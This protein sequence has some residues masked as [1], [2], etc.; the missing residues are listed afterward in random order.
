[1]Q[2]CSDQLESLAA[3]SPVLMIFEDVHWIDPTSL[4]L[5]ERTVDSVERWPVLLVI[6]F[7][8]EFQPPWVGLAHVTMHRLNKLNRRES[9][10]L[11]RSA[12]RRQTAAA[13]SRGA[14]HRAH[15]WRAAVHGGADQD[16]A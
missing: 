6:T 14:D 8:P 1:M 16:G 2:P 12:D 5:L 11:I 4:E 15:R 10:M 7:R 13:G 9:A 3:K